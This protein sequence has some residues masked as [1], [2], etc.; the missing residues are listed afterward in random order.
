MPHGDLFTTN[1]E[2]TS[3][4]LHLTRKSLHLRLLLQMSDQTDP[5]SPNECHQVQ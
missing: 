5:V 3:D 1:P 2:F 4:G